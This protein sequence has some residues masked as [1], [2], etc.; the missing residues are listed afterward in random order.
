ML[1]QLFFFLVVTC[2]VRTGN[3]SVEINEEITC[4][5][6]YLIQYS[7]IF[8]KKL[9]RTFRP[10]ISLEMIKAS[11]AT[12]VGG[13]LEYITLIM[14]IQPQKKLNIHFSKK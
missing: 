4:Y 9:G 6:S 12:F 2:F 13:R 10:I 1:S 14:N 11:K 8:V 3:F 7:F 5:F